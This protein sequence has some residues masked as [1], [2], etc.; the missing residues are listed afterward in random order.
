MI[1]SNTASVSKILRNYF[2]EHLGKTENEPVNDTN[3][4]LRKN[5]EGEEH[6]YLHTDSPSVE[7]I[8]KAI[9]DS[10][11]D[12]TSGLDKIPAKLHKLGRKIMKTQRR[13]LIGNMDE[14]GHA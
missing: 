12:R 14:R 5:Q 10:K 2:Q 4:Q 8:E 11:N 6:D 1:I 7:K 9:K 13:K 3:Q